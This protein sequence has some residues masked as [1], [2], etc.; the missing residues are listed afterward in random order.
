[1]Q[2]T[3]YKQLKDCKNELF[4]LK[5]M[6]DLVSLIDYQFGAW[7]STLWDKINTDVLMA[8][9]QEMKN[10]Q[11]SPTAPQN[12]DIKNWKAFQSLNDR[13]KNMNT[14]LPLI[15]QLHSKFMQERHW[16]KLMKITEQPVDFKSPKFCLEDLIKLE[17]Y[18]F[19]ED[20]TEL[21]EGAQKEDKIETKLNSI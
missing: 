14:I 13:V 19:S 10:K 3:T 18:N 7:T 2:K 11:C 12:K 21:V 16:R 15:N 5:Q 6:W 8:L 17:L 4:H 9:I 20:V 1:M